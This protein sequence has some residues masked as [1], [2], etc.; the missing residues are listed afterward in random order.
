L[1]ENR[2][3]SLK[4]IDELFDEIN[5]KLNDLWS[6][7]EKKIADNPE[8][9][10]ESIKKSFRTLEKGVVLDMENLKT[11]LKKVYL[12]RKNELKDVLR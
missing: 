1:T 9:D 4:E 3:T 10:V 6:D 7:L 11:K 5:N 8:K 2:K 12:E